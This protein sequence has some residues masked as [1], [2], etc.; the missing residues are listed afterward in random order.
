MA[1]HALFLGLS[2]NGVKALLLEQKREVVTRIGDCRF[3]DHVYPCNV[4]PQARLR[5]ATARL[6]QDPSSWQMED[7]VFT[8]AAAGVQLQPSAQA[9]QEEHG[10]QA[11]WASSRLAGRFLLPTPD[12]I[13]K[14]GDCYFESREL[15][16]A[17]E[18]KYALNKLELQQCGLR[19]RLAAV[20]YART[21]GPNHEL[22]PGVTLGAL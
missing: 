3:Y 12:V 1:A 21:L 15:L 19:R 7:F 8:P 6:S 16:L 13:D 14:A 22:S 18:G 11:L 17:H 2:S 5:D 4:D 9:P 10:L 20:A